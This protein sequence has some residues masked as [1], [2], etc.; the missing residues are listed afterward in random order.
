MEPGRG[1]CAGIEVS[2]NCGSTNTTSNGMFLVNC[3]VD[4]RIDLSTN[5]MTTPFSPARPVRPER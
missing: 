1:D 5:E 3:V 2:T 4:L